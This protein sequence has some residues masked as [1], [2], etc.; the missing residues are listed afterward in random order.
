M[1]TYF[2]TIIIVVLIFLLV[3]PVFFIQHI[4]NVTDVNSYQFTT[5]PTII[6]DAGHGGEDGGAV[7]VTG[8][9]E[10]DINLNIAKKLNYFLLSAGY[11]TKMTRDDDSSVLS[12]GTTYSKHNDLQNRVDVFNSSQNNIAVSI[13][14][15][16]FTQNQYYGTQIFYSPNNE[17]SEYLAN[18]I[19]NSVVSLLQ[20]KNTRECKKSGSEILILNKSSVPTVLVE[21]G[22]LSNE[23]EAKLLDNED[24]QNKIAYSIFLGILEFENT[25][26]RNDING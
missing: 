21:C 22:F 1:K 4:K 17:R 9:L 19:R 15:N 18:N 24:Y 23:A 16:K 3:F 11:S 12:D 6:I 10:K 14:Q 26:I 5:K 20:N 25:K 8:T 13:H 7:S 2:N